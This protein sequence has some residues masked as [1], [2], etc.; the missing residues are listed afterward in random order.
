MALYGPDERPSFTHPKLAFVQA[1]T[2]ELRFENGGTLQIDCWQDDDEFAL[3]PRRVSPEQR[4]SP[5][6]DPLNTIFR[7][8]QMSEFPVGWIRRVEWQIDERENIQVISLYFDSTELIICAGEVDE[9]MDGT[10][11]V[12]KKDESV[13]IFL[14]RAAY[15]RT[16]FN[17]PAYG[18]E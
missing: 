13:L 2:L 6:N 7:L 11:T 14:D 8:R 3:C 15:E 16:V 10:L 1:L 4:L 18:I 5:T 9:G 12:F 17:T